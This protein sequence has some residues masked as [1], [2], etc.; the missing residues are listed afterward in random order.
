MYFLLLLYVYL[1]ILWIFCINTSNFFCLQLTAQFC[2]RTKQR[3]TKH[4]QHP[5][6]QPQRMHHKGLQNNANKLWNTGN[7]LTVAKGVDPF[8]QSQR[9]P[10]T[11]EFFKTDRTPL[12]KG[13]LKSFAKK[14]VLPVEKITEPNSN[15]LFLFSEFLRSCLIC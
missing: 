7:L 2:K 12:A 10:T 3:N 6:H 13:S 14:C 9:P 1:T 11:F 15:S 8:T 5:E 4:Q